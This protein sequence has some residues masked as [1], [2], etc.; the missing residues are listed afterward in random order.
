MPIYEY[1]CTD[2]GHR[3]EALQKINADPLLI[4]PECQH[5]SLRKLVSA[6]SF[7]LKG[8]GWYETDFKQS[9]K[10]H[11]A[12]SSDSVDRPVASGPVKA[13]EKSTPA[14]AP[15]KSSDA[16]EVKKESDK[17][18]KVETKTSS[19]GPGSGAGAVNPG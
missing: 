17:K 16:K 18:P 11:L 5:S 6:P 3:M 7:R 2:C 9:G 12:D 13:D 8:S 19:S 10:K 14:S 1:Q 4:C 15:E